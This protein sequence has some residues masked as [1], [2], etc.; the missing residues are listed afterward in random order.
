MGYNHRRLKQNHDKHIERYKN[1]PQDL[2]LE[3]IVLS[4]DEVNIFLP[5]GDGL[6]AQ[7]DNM[8]IDK[9]GHLTIVEYKGGSGRRQRAITQLYNAADVIRKLYRLDA[10]LLYVH[11]DDRKEYIK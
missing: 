10:D 11:G 2:G 9:Y 3:N 5:N 6:I 1:N 7:P 8:F 4:A